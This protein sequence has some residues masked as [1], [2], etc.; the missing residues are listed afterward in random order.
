MMYNEDILKIPLEDLVQPNTIVAI[1]CTNSPTHSEFVKKVALP[2]WNL[3]LLTTYYWVKVKD[4]SFNGRSFLHLILLDLRQIT[5]SGDPVCEFHAPLKKQPY[6]QLFLAAHIESEHVTRFD[7]MNLI[8]S[9]P[10]VIHSHK[11]P[12]LGK[13]NFTNNCSWLHEI[14][15]DCLENGEYNDIPFVCRHF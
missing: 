9:I 11:P 14:Y 4:C 7:D 5:K 3:K 2:K 10:S 8:F 6:E 12:L 13:R 1:W 15:A